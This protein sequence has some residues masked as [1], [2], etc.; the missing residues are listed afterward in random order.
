MNQRIPHF[1]T[2]ADYSE[3]PKKTV[4]Q[5]DVDLAYQENW[6]NERVGPLPVWDP[7]KALVWEKV[8]H[9]FFSERVV[10]ISSTNVLLL[11][12]GDI[13]YD[14]ELARIQ[15]ESDLLAWV[16]HLTGKDWINPERLRIFIEAVATIKG[17]QIRL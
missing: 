7:S 16:C 4:D 8:F 14:I 9:Q 13:D 1:S 2:V 5:E 6:E 10:F 3:L 11:R 12:F 15:S 17:F